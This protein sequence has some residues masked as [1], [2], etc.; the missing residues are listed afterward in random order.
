MEHFKLMVQFLDKNELKMELT[1][2]VR[3]KNIELEKI[4]AN[5]IFQRKLQGNY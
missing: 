1:V 5:E 3:S 4:I 2:A